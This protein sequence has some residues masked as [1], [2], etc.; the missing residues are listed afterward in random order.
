[1]K[2]SSTRSS[3]RAA[4]AARRFEHPGARAHAD[5]GED[6]GAAGPLVEGEHGERGLGVVADVQVGGSRV[7]G[8]LE[9]RHAESEERSRAVERE[10]AAL[11]QAAK[12]GGIEY[13]DAAAGGP[14][15]GRREFAGERLCARAVEVGDDEVDLRIRRREV[16]ARRCAHAAGSAEDD[17]S[18]RLRGYGNGVPPSRGRLCAR[19]APEIA[20]ACSAAPA[21]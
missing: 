11:E 7:D 9:G 10:I 20:G 16:S 1:M 3:R 19:G 12:R 14:R 15:P 17:D 21:T 8:R 13:I 6:P 4:R 5:H 2:Q 18:H